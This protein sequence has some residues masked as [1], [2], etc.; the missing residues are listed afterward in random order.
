MAI[1]VNPLQ[2]PALAA[3]AGNTIGPLGLKYEGVQPGLFQQ[4]QAQAL[5]QQGQLQNEQERNQISAQNALLQELGANTRND[6]TLFAQANQ[7][8]LNRQQ[9]MKLAMIQRAMKDQELQ[10]NAGFK[11]QEL[12]LRSQEIQQQGKFQQGSLQND[13]QRLELEKTQKAIEVLAKQSEEKRNQLGAYGSTYMYMHQVMG[14]TPEFKQWSNSFFDDLAASGTIT[15][16]EA[17]QHKK[18]DINQNLGSAAWLV[19]LSKNANILAEQMKPTAP[20]AIAV[21]MKERDDLLSERAKLV[22]EKKDTTDIDSKIKEYNYQLSGKPGVIKSILN[23]AGDVISSVGEGIKN[24]MTPQTSQ[25]A[26]TQTIT[27]KN[28]TYN[29]KTGQLE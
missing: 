26:S 3:L 10:Q 2:V 8:D 25:Q 12:G 18:A 13:Q 1:N 4:A 22:Q 20:S 27:K 24:T 11:Q 28:L 19:G 15:K 23:S 9:E 5:F 6:N 7:Y 16:Q 29:P 17:E 21:Q 14:D